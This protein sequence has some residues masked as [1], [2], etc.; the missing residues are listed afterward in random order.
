MKHVVCTICD[1]G[2]QLRAEVKDGRVAKIHPHEHPILAKNICFKGT[3]A[4]QIHNHEQRLLHP[5]KR[6]GARGEGRWE[7]I[8]YEQALDEIAERLTSIVAEH[9][10]EAL[11][12]STSTGTPRSRTAWAAGS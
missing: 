11:A 2:C 12:V 4:P 9:G 3:A 6:V 1:I 10:P 8:T 7:Q 5:L